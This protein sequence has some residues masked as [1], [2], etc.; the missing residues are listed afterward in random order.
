M[1]K[2]IEVKGLVKKYNNLT[3]VKGIDFYVNKGELFAFLGTNGAGKSTTIDILC[4]LKSYTECR[5]GSRKG[6]WN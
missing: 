4:T 5:N 6:Y 3:A 2:I 1:D